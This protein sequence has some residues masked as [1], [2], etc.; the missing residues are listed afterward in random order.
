VADLGNGRTCQL[1]APNRPSAYPLN[2][3]LDGRLPTFHHE[4]KL[5]GGPFREGKDVRDGADGVRHE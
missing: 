4:P 3:H 5:L 2:P 1:T